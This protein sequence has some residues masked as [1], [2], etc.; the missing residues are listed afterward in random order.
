MT[1]GLAEPTAKPRI[2]LIEDDGD[3]RSLVA[4]CLAAEELTI[5]EAPDGRT[6]DRV[7]SGKG[8][9]LIVLDI[10]LPGE[11]GFD[12]CTRLR[13]AGGPPIIMLTA[14]VEDVDRILGLELGADDY[15]TKPFNPREL[16]AR[17]RAVLRRSRNTP[18]ANDEHASYAF[19]GFR[20]DG[21]KRQLF[22]PDGARVVVTTSEFD[23]LRTLLEAGGRVLSRED[24]RAGI[25][26]SAS[27]NDRSVD[28]VVSR[29][30]QKI[31]PDPKNPVMVQTIRSLGYVFTPVVTRL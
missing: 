23:A 12:I 6:A 4:R 14:R 13:R 9:D 29:L 16:L 22:D 3:I 27:S 1:L 20:F 10:N 5:L 15:L 18:E 2:L 21:R 17:I 30:R 31:E 25:S 7:L 24:L 8:V 28:I 19:E 11:D 26:P